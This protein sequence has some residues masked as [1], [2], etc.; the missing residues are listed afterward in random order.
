MHTF[1]DFRGVFI[2]LLLFSPCSFLC[3]LIFLLLFLPHHLLLYLL[4]LPLFPL[5]SSSFSS[6]ISFFFFSFFFMKQKK[7]QKKKNNTSKAGQCLSVKAIHSNCRENPL[8][9]PLGF[10]GAQVEK[11]WS[12]VTNE[13]S[14]RLSLIKK[15]HSITDLTKTGLFGYIRQRFVEYTELVSL[16]M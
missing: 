11:R 6:S 4:L 15:R 3:L 9:H 16:A 12:N 8:L 10:R 2:L 14:L 13:A 1:S 7:T 5:S